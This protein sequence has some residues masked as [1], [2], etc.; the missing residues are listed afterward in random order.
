MNGYVIEL[1]TI[2]SFSIGFV[3]K[4]ST[5][6][7]ALEARI[8]K[9]KE[10]FIKELHGLEI[11]VEQMKGHLAGCAK[12]D[13]TEIRHNEMRHQQLTAEIKAIKNR[14]T[15]IENVLIKNMDY[16]PR[17]NSRNGRI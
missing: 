2:V 15:D 7:R 4:L 6:T 8:T 10:T 12:E 9:N 13:S 1:L 16:K 11:T 17:R 14:I 3:W 5:T